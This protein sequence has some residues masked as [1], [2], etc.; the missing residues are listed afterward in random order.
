MRRKQH[1]PESKYKTRTRD[2]KVQ[3]AFD[4]ALSRLL[5]TI[6]QSSGSAL[7]ASFV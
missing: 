6:Y 5:N 2:A 1:A 7:G 4:E 3:E